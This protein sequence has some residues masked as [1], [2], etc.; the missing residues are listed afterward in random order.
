MLPPRFRA[1]SRDKEVKYR[2]VRAMLDSDSAIRGQHGR[3]RSRHPA[4]VLRLRAGADAPAVAH[5]GPDRVARA[6]ALLGPAHA[7]DAERGWA[8]LH[9]LA[10]ALGHPRHAAMGSVF[11]HGAVRVRGDDLFRLRAGRT[12]I[13]GR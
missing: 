4:A 6:R 8:G 12:R 1:T 11:H 10:A 5:R 7:R 3:L 9:Q 2:T 13:L